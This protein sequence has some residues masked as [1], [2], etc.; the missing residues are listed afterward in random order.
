[1]IEQQD[2]LADIKAQLAKLE[3][4][5]Y[6]ITRTHLLIDL[7]RDA[8][9]WLVGEVECSRQGV[10][11]LRG[12]LRELEWAG[13]IFCDQSCCPACGVAWSENGEHAEDCWLA[14]ELRT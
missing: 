7:G 9:P 14:A 4:E 6:T 2:R 1:V 3:T 13:G 8:A 10:E 12:R 11:D 5:P